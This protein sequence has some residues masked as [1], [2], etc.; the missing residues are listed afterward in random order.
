MTTP[1]KTTAPS[2]SVP[3]D[4]T[5]LAHTLTTLDTM[6]RI[7][8]QVSTM[9]PGEQG[10][11]LARLAEGGIALVLQYTEGDACSPDVRKAIKELV[12]KVRAEN[13]VSG[14][15]NP[16]AKGQEPTSIGSDAKDA[17]DEKKDNGTLRGKR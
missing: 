9:A 8:A 7:L 15:A 4:L 3:V 6:A 13:T 5:L 10:V 12:F 16:P 14:A 2:L 11:S 17:K 1:H